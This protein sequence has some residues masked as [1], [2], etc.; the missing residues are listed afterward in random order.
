MIGLDVGVQLPL[1]VLSLKHAYLRIEISFFGTLTQTALRR[2]SHLNRLINFIA[3][4]S[5]QFNYLFNRIAICFDPKINLPVQCE[6]D[7]LLG[8][9]EVIVYYPTRPSKIDI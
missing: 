5:F 2:L 1:F 8:M 9:G 7:C 4:K 3:K 6:Y